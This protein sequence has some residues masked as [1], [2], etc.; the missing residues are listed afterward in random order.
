MRVPTV[1][2]G[3]RQGGRLRS[4]SVLDCAPERGAIAAALET[5]LDPAF[6]QRIADQELPFQGC[7]YDGMARILATTDLTV[8]SHKKFHDLPG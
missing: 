3:G 2:I 1:N 7:D 5:A 4:A 6:R 8:L